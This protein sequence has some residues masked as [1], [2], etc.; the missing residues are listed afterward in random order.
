MTPLPPS[1]PAPNPADAALAARAAARGPGRLADAQAAFEQLYRLHARPLVAFIASRVPSA[2]A[3]DLHQT[4]WA[5]AW[6][7]MPDQFDGGHVRGWLFQIARNLIIDR[8]RKKR[9]DSAD[10]IGD[11]PDPR[12]TGPSAGLEEDDDRRRLAACMD[13]LPTALRELV[14]GRLAGDDYET[15]AA[16]LNIPAARAHRLFHDAKTKLEGCVQQADP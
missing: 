3:D 4:V 16:R 10:K 15:V 9:E 6:E 1:P 5:K 13:K 12:L 7:R 8:G 11:R 14:R 2:D